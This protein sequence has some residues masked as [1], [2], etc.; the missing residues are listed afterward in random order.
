L[1][2]APEIIVDVREQRLRRKVIREY[3]VVWRGFH[4]EDV[5]WEGE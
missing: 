2:L 1:V 4:A 3:L 5:T